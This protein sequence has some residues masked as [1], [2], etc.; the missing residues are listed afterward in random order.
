MPG[1]RGESDAALNYRTVRSACRE[2]EARDGIEPP[3]K[4]LQTLPFSFWVPRRRCKQEFWVTY[5]EQL[6]CLRVIE[7]IAV[8]HCCELKAAILPISS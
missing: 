4:A 3:N 7:K 1:E 5:R 2:V 6:P 8:D